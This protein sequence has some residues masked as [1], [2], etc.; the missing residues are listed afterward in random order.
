MASFRNLPLSHRIGRRLSKYPLP[1]G[2]AAYELLNIFVP[3]RK[4]NYVIKFF[5]HPCAAPWYV[6]AELAAPAFAGMFITLLEFGR[7]D[8][9]RMSAG[10]PQ[11]RFLRKLFRKGSR[12][13]PTNAVNA[14]KFFWRVDFVVQKAF[15]WWMIAD[16]TVDGLYKWTTMVNET[17]WCTGEGILQA[18]VLNSAQPCFNAW[19]GFVIPDVLQN[20]EP[21]PY[22]GISVGLGPSSYH[23]ILTLSV[24]SNSP[25]NPTKNFQVR[26][27]VV[28]GGEV[29]I[30]DSAPVDLKLGITTDVSV[31]A[32]W[33]TFAASTATISWQWRIDNHFINFVNIDVAHVI[34]ADEGS[35]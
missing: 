30:F 33:R 2:S 31:T 21:W 26:F 32:A 15:F 6:Y 35:F 20:T 24:K 10:R 18:E 29:H 28:S 7:G 4:V 17:I 34:V 23:A 27:T 3:A 14:L 22:I 9:L 13:A 19:T 11:R 8:I 1:P 5:T 25:F 16:L 12:V